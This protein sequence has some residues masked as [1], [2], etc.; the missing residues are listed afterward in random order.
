[1]KIEIIN[2]NDIYYP[3]NLLE[4]YNPPKQLY[5][6]GDKEILNSFNIAIIGCRLNS[7][8]GENVAKELAY[9]LS[10]LGIV[11]TSGLAKGI[12]TYSHIGCLNAKGKTIAVLGSGLYN[13]YPKEN[14]KIAKQIVENG[15]TIISEYEPNEKPR[16]ENFPSRNRIISGIS[17]GVVVVEAKEKSGTFITVD[18][19]LEQGKNIFAVPG[20]I[21]SKNSQ[22]TNELIKQGAKIVTKVED[23]IEEYINVR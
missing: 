20:N 5:V 14:I 10:K 23:I 8:Y 11:I 12:D 7:K 2:Q 4:I 3:K 9:K 16:K 6:L 22:G 19:A 1:M 21:L 18:L 15:G 17:N 13:I